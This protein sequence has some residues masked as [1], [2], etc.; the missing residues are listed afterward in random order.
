MLTNNATAA[1]SGHMVKYQFEI[2]DDEWER[3][4]N[5]VPRSKALDQRIRE[6]IQADADGRVDESQSETPE[7]QGDVGSPLRDDHAPDPEPRSRPEADVDQLREE[8]AGSGDLLDRRVDAI[9]DMY[10]YLVEHGEAEKSDLLG[11]VDVDEVGYQD[12]ESVWSNMVKGCDTLRALDG[13]GTP[14]EGK[15]TWRYSNDP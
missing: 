2:D 15:T 14:P 9:L 7:V 8:L 6:L 4:K 1:D 11:A 3:W 12:A 10:D 5:T 13:V